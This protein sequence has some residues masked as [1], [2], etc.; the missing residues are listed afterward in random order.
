MFGNWF[1]TAVKTNIMLTMECEPRV[2]SLPVKMNLANSEYEAVL[3]SS[4][5]KNNLGTSLNE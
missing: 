2:L 4:V 3:G 1:G 5:R